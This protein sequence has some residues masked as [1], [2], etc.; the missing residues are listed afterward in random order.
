MGDWAI[1][2]GTSWEGWKWGSRQEIALRLARRGERVLYVEP[3]LGPEYL[4]SNPDAHGARDLR[5]E[6]QR[7]WICT[8]PR[9]P[10]G[11]W[12]LRSLNRWGQARVAAG[13]RRV[14]AGIGFRDPVL[15]ASLAYQADLV[16]RVPH[17]GVIYH[18]TDPARGRATGRR[19]ALLEGMHRDLV[20]A[21]GRVLVA[22]RVLEE[23]C[24]RIAP[25]RA[26][27]FPPG[28]DLDAFAR[29]APR[30]SGLSPPVLAVCG[31]LNDRIEWGWLDA[32]L[33]GG[34]GSLLLLGTIETRSAR[35]WVRDRAG[36]GRVLA[37]GHIPHGEVAGWLAGAQAGLIPYRVD[38]SEDA[39]FP[40]KLWEYLAAG[41][42]VAA[43][44]LPEVDTL[45]DA[46]APW[47]HTGSGPE[48]FAQAVCAALAALRGEPPAILAGQDWEARVDELLRITASDEWGQ[49]VRTV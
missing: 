36:T 30:P 18:Y 32:L 48:G 20:R 47:V 45:R 11:R 12:L 49:R 21:S 42:P 33:S 43:S 35:A 3:T 41:L 28:V 39:T 14:L 15:W 27:R 9:I 10:P 31:V 46:C 17:R 19:A 44:P 38:G 8:P 34:V 37:P 16:G 22:S 5:Q 4:L 13:L 23:E 29:A 7:L 25:G 40:M 6:A 1:L 24:E 26:R 2:S